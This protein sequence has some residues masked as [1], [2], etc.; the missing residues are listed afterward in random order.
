[1]IIFKEPTSLFYICG[2]NGKIETVA[3]LFVAVQE[4]QCVESCELPF[5][6]LQV[7]ATC[8]LCQPATELN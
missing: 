5:A 7:R 1:M 6:V 8:Q 2:M 3:C 4:Q